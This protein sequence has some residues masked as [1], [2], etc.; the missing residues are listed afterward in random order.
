MDFIRSN[1]WNVQDHVFGY[2]KPTTHRPPTLYP[3]MFVS[4]SQVRSCCGVRILRCEIKEKNC[5]ALIIPP[6]SA[7][8]HHPLHSGVGVGKH[9][10]G[11]ITLRS[12]GRIHHQKPLRL[13]LVFCSVVQ[14]MRGGIRSILPAL[15]L[16]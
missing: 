8:Q 2:M 12:K 16:A 9:S 7:M 13:A 15:S 14:M 6:R 3:E 1:W 5:C 4:T 10:Q 11:M